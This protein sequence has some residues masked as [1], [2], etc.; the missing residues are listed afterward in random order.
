[1][2]AILYKKYGPPDVLNLEEVQ[3]PTPKDNE[4]L[5]KVHAASVVSAP[6][7]YLL[8]S[9]LFNSV[10]KYSME[11][12]SLPFIITIGALFLPAI[13]TVSSQINRVVSVNPVDNLRTE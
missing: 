6:I 12:T 9:L 10:Y 4:V 2:K 8:V 3:K 5:I 11:W 7:S 13:L 1:M